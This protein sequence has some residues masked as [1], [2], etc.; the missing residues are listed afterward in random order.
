MTSARAYNLLQQLD[1][2][3][4]ERLH[5]RRWWCSADLQSNV[6]RPATACVFE[7]LVSGQT[8]YEQLCH[9]C[10]LLVSCR[11]QDEGRAGPG[12]PGAGAGAMC[13]HAFAQHCI[14]KAMH[15]KRMEVCPFF[16]LVLAL[17][18]CRFCRSL[19]RRCFVGMHERSYHHNE[20]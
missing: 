11:H 2:S 15:A 17:H 10:Y 20:D 7:P 14:D 5:G 12:S 16:V 8:M 4:C 19:V 9:G 13:I 18:A 1:N 3:N 6:P